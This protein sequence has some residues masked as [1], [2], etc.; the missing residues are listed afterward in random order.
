MSE[1]IKNDYLLFDSS[2]MDFFNGLRKTYRAGS[3]LLKLVLLLL[4]VVQQRS[5]KAG[6]NERHFTK[7][8][9]QM[10]KISYN[11]TDQI[12]GSV[13]LLLFRKTALQDQVVTLLFKL[14]SLIYPV[15]TNGC[16]HF[17]GCVTC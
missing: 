15:V 16:R 10:R 5:S 4:Q 17:V 7:T 11:D 14:K 13:A 8:R 6:S 3:L 9:K 1:V 2:C 12:R